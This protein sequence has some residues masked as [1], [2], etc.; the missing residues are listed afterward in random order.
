MSLKTYLSHLRGGGV[1][2]DAPL[3]PARA[4]YA[5]GD[6]H[7]CH[8]LLMQALDRVDADLA[9][10]GLEADLV[11]LGDYI[12]RGP[13]T[14]QVLDTLSGLAAVCPI[15][16]TCLMGNHERMLL[17][18]LDDPARHAA[19]WLRNGGHFTL[20]SYGI[21]AM[22]SGRAAADVMGALGRAM[23]APVQTWLRD[24]PALWC[25]GNLVAVHAGADPVVPIDVQDA[26]VFL[27]GTPDFARIPRRDGLWVV[28]GH[29]IVPAPMMRDGRIALD[30]G[31]YA[32]GRLT[33]ARLDPGAGALT[34]I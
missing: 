13:Q 34:L 11:L 12:D 21:D 32:T 28:H 5:V 29:T 6:I 15:P 10:H 23:P 8:D 25:S 1:R 30:T 9:R 31:A 26:S 4:V 27:W 24:L 20:A 16:V 17:E 18:A 33:V 2:F 14:A 19:R 22:E 7:G 3:A